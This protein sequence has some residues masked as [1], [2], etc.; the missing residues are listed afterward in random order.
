MIFLVSG[1]TI[2]LNK[3]NWQFKMNLI[4]LF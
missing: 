1:L 3:I 4:Y 2:F